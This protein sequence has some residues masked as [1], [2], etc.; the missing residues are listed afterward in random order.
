MKSKLTK[1]IILI[2]IIL[3]IILG[4]LFIPKF[5]R[6][7][8]YKNYE[9]YS[10]FVDKN[11]YTDLYNNKKSTYYEL[12]T[13]E[14]TGRIIYKL[15]TNL[16]N[17]TDEY[18]KFSLERNYISNPENKNY[19]ELKNRNITEI[20]VL[21]YL[22]NM[23]NSFFESVNNT[24]KVTI[25]NESEFTSEQKLALYDMVNNKVV[26]SADEISGNTKITKGKLNKIVSSFYNKYKEYIES[27]EYE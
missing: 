5:Y 15:I 8:K 17:F 1:I 6:M 7:I 20:E 22:Y 11:G 2:I 27:E 10:E 26:D 21:E 9:S 12:V 25:D 19:T 13:Y 3:L 23:K 16:D 18:T 14:E 4:Y 24:Q